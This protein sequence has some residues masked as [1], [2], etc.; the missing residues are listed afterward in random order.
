MT[1]LTDWLRVFAA[2]QAIELAIAGPLLRSAEPRRLYRL[3]LIFV[4]TLVT[5]PVVWFVFPR[6]GLRYAAMVWA[7]E[8][9]A[10][11]V[12]AALY[13]HA[14]PRLGAPRAVLVAAA[15]NAGSLILVGIVRFTTGAL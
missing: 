1:P 7:S 6:I 2:T 12:E 3:A 8:L 4:A 15:A 10:W 13:A 14:L 5:H 11:L 9:F